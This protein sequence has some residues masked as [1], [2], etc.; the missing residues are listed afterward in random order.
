MEYTLKNGKTVLIRPICPDDAEGMVA[1]LTASDYETPFLSRNPGELNLTVEKERS[2]IE[3]FLENKDAAKFCALCDGKL[4]GHC[5]IDL[6]RFRQRFRHRAELGFLLLK[7]FW[8]LGIGSRMMEECISWAKEHDVLQL[9]LD[10]V[11]QNERA[12]ALYRKYGFEICGTL[13]RDLRYPDGTF[14]DE[15]RMI[16]IL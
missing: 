14:A 11:T 3:S 10:V 13:P 7:D 9:E 6:I 4:V 2:L 12:M 16:K 8:G 1:L 5:S 15:Y